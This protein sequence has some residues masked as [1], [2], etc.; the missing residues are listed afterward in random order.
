MMNSSTN[1][2]PRFEFGQNF[3][4]KTKSGI[5]SAPVKHSYK[6]NEVEEIRAKAFEE[7]QRLAEEGLIQVQTRA[8]ENLTMAAY[9]SLKQLET[10]LE[11]NR[12]NSLRLCVAVA[13]K[14]AGGALDQ[15]PSLPLEA[16]M[17]LLSLELK[18]QTSLWIAHQGLAEEAIVKIEQDLRDKG[19]EGTIQWILRPNEPKAWFEIE[20]GE[21][22]A[23]FD[24]EHIASEILNALSLTPTKPNPLLQDAD[25]E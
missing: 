21:G 3:G 8:L 22:R 7:G 14:L 5:I 4:P 24:P 9:E 17:R 2:Y 1:A 15:A 16:A 25:Y 6:P 23:S 20:W 11:D 18:R 19:F 10:E 12:Q 13:Q